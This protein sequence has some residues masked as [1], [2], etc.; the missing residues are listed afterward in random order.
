MINNT[1]HTS[2]LVI[3]ILFFASAAAGQSKVLS[4][5]GFLILSDGYK[6]YLDSLKTTDVINFPFIPNVFIPVRQFEKSENLVKANFR[7]ENLNRG[8]AVELS[9]LDSLT[10]YSERHINSLTNQRCY[11]DSL[12]HIVAVEIKYV[13]LNRTKHPLVCDDPIQLGFD[14]RMVIF[15]FA[16]PEVRIISLRRL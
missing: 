13:Y 3:C 2:L 4:S 15:S 6:R 11:R 8:F 12:F 9:T 16:N 14:D 10:R 1:L 5:R 7:T